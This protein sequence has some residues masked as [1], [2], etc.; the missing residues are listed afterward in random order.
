MSFHWSKRTDNTVFPSFFHVYIS[1]FSHLGE[2]FKRLDRCSYYKWFLI[3]KTSVQ[4]CLTQFECR[5]PYSLLRFMALQH[6]CLRLFLTVV[7]P[8]SLHRLPC[9]VLF[10]L[11]PSPMYAIFSPFFSPFPFFMFRRFTTG[12]MEQLSARLPKL[13]V[14]V[15]FRSLAAPHILQ[16]VFGLD[17]LL[18]GDVIYR[19]D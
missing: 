7:V 12:L 9:S 6:C 2:C 17:L 5:H 10:V 16:L 4:S 3:G 15:W 18:C 19:C 14:H 11:L 13:P 1:I 8:S